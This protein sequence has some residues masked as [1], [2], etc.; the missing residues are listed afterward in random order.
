MSSWR[1]ICAA[2]SPVWGR[3]IV[4]VPPRLDF[5]AMLT[6]GMGKRNRPECSLFLGRHTGSLLAG[7]GQADGDGLLGIGDLLLGAS[8]LE[9]SFFH[10]VHRPFDFFARGGAV[11]ASH[12]WPPLLRGI[13]SYS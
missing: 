5:S 7:F 13:G 10:L 1:V 2:P 8:A 9:F 3:S 4:A 6:S 11:L 12:V